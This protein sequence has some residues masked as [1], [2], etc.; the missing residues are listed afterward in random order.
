[1][2]LKY[3]EIKKHIPEFLEVYKDRPIENNIGGMMLPHLYATWFM[4]RELNPDIIIESGTFKG[5]GT[6]IMEQACPD[7]KI[8]SID[9]RDQR[10]YISKKVF[11]EDSD[12]TEFDWDLMLMSGKAVIHF[13]DHQNALERII[14]AKERG[15]KHLIF[16]DNY[17]EG[18]GDCVSLKQHPEVCKKL[19]QYIEFPPIFRLEYTRWGDK[20]PMP[21]P[22]CSNVT[23]INKPFFDESKW[24][25]W[26]AYV[27][28]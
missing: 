7:A 8:T 5:L 21:E 14:W 12:I 16:E 25:T 17:P 4:L 20:I 28:L 3:K 18:K 23:V 1:M 13:D 2:N 27:N 15:F 10:E 9:I 26:I 6:W 22:V 19:K 11:Y 24:Y